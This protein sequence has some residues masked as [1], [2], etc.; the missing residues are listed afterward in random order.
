MPKQSYKLKSSSTK[1]S[2]LPY[3]I[4]GGTKKIPKKQKS[5]C[6]IE[7]CLHIAH[8]EIVRDKSD[9]AKELP[10]VIDNPED[11][12][13][14]LIEVNEDGVLFNKPDDPLKEVNNKFVFL[15]LSFWSKSVFKQIYKIVLIHSNSSTAS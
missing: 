14:E 8:D 13:I 1:N 15:L 3:L 6:F 11:E 10:P 2:I 12:M 5:S 4:S 7:K 9:V